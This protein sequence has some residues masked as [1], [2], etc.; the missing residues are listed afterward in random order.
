[1]KETLKE[2]EARGTIDVVAVEGAVLIEA[3]TH[4]MFDELWVT[5]LDKEA[6]VQRVMKRNP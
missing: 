4:T 3:N 2:I 5:T 6:A 1:L